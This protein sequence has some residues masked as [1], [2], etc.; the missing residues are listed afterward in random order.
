MIDE[1]LDRIK[2]YRERINEAQRK[3]YTENDDYYDDEEWDSEEIDDEEDRNLEELDDEERFS[4][5]GKPVEIPEEIYFDETVEIITGQNHWE[6]QSHALRPIRYIVSQENPWYFDIDGV[7]YSKETGLLVLF[8]PGKAEV[9]DVPN[10]ERITG[11]GN[12]AFSGNHLL[13][14][15]NLN[16][17]IQ[18]IDSQAFCECIAVEEIIIPKSVEYLGSSAFKGCTSLKKAEICGPVGNIAYRLFY[19]DSNLEIVRYTNDITT[20]GTN[21][22][23]GCS[24]LT[25]VRPFGTDDSSYDLVL[26]DKLCE[27]GR[28]AF[29]G[30]ERIRTVYVPEGVKKIGMGAFSG[31]KALSSISTE[32]VQRYDGNCFQDCISL[33]RFFFSNNSNRLGKEIF[34]GANN[35]KK[36]SFSCSPSFTCAVD[37]LPE[38]VKY[39]VDTEAYLAA[40]KP[41]ENKILFHEC[42]YNIVGGEY[43]SEDKVSKAVRILKRNRKKLYDWFLESDEIL[44]FVLNAEIPD[45]DNCV[46]MMKLVESRDPVKTDMIKNFLHGHFTQS[47]ITEAVK[48]WEEDNRARQEA[49]QKARMMQEKKEKLKKELLSSIPPELD[50]TLEEMGLSVRA[51]NC[52]KRNGINSLSELIEMTQEDLMKVRNL[53]RK[54]MEEAVSKIELFT[55]KR[56]PLYRDE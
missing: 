12:N 9:Y 17:R 16:N 44:S 29:S 22:F 10:D 25:D 21:A 3:Q 41:F 23:G 42:V 37:A 26:P 33:E 50:I 27:I 24:S 11:I 19:W 46:A 4:F 39:S 47:K 2:S 28:N 1:L 31:C 48:R 8:P 45:C 13:K 53:G 14:K 54:S 51:Y 7:V 38:D 20:I 30:C 15:V 52:L 43:V 55:G 40:P 32:S 34:K 18:Y 6:P 36:I 49:E 35:L 56:I 5:S